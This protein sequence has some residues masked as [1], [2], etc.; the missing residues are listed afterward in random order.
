MRN[1]NYFSLVCWWPSSASDSGDS[2][3]LIKPA[4]LVTKWK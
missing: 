2:L 3:N 1:L 4:I